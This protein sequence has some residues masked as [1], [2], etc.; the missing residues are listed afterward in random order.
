MADSPK[1]RLNF[2]K[3]LGSFT[4]A[5]DCALEEKVSAFLGVS[6][7]GKSTL[8][9]CISGILTPDEGEIVFGDE[10]LYSSTSK[11]NLP[12]EKR[13]FGYIFQ[14]GYLFPHL[15]VAQNIRY[16]QPNSRK[17]SE[18]IDVLEISE[19]LQRYPRQLSGG[20]RQRV[21]IARALAM[22]PRML[23]MDE[24]LAALDSALKDRI[25]PYL[26]HVKNAFEIP[27]LYITHAFSE[28]MALADEAFLIANGEII[29]NGE[30]HRLLT[31]PSA[32]PI[33]QLTGIENI[34][35][36]PV[37]LSDEALGVTTLE[38][39]NQSLV[40]PYTQAEVGE[41]VPVAVRA[42]DIIISLEPNLPVSARNILRGTIQYLDV[43]SERTWVSILV[44]WHH[45]A[46]KITHQAREQMQ[47]RQDLEVYC[48]IKASAINRLWD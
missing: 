41:I 43:R 44:E 7:S 10:I 1:I 28:A 40:I 38:I 11:I 23:L 27:I 5:V 9:N 37:T 8:L 2:R 20:Q 33:A 36:L 16:G 42:E 24:P 18:A 22:E 30:P 32:M 13:R 25:I 14:E 34:L 3:S 12:P 17:S 4:L 19:L 48:V 39:G 31:A 26:H 6:G 45:L 21:A 47:L 15:T 29:A 35:L 46:V